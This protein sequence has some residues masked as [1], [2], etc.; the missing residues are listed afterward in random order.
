MIACCPGF[1]DGEQTLIWLS[2][3]PEALII[4]LSMEDIARALDA[5]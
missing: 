5:T 2:G 3:A 1:N 4:D